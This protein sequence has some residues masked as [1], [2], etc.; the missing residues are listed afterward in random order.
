M[1]T[2]D[3]YGYPVGSNEL[4]NVTR[5]VQTVRA[6]TCDGAGGIL[7]DNRPGATTTYTYNKRNR[8]TSATFGGAAVEL[9]LQSCLPAFGRTSRS[10]SPF[11]R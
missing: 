8:L 6:I 2:D 11:A 3:V 7:T 1:I 10:S 5:G 9:R 4:A